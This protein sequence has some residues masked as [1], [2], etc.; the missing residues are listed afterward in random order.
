LFYNILDT[1]CRPDQ[2]ILIIS[3]LDGRVVA[4]DPSGGSVLWSFDSG[5]PLLSVQQSEA[6]PPGVHIFPG[7]DG[8][9]YAYHG[10]DSNKA[11]LEVRT[12]KRIME[13]YETVF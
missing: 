6:S 8:G 10:L 9:L 11:R 4:V 12:L 5:S 2:D 13:Q 7:V 1:P 3:L